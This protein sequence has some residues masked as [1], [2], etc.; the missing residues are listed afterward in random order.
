ML[1]RFSR[2]WLFVTP[3]TVVCQAPL[4]TGFSRQGY[5]SGL[6]CPPPGDLPDPGVKPESLLSPAL[7]GRFFTT[8]ATWEV[9][10][11]AYIKIYDYTDFFQVY[12]G[13]SK[14]VYL[15]EWKRKKI[16]NVRRENNGKWRH[17]VGEC[18]RQPGP[19]RCPCPKSWD[20]LPCSAGTLKILLRVTEL[21][22]GR[23]S[24]TVWVGPI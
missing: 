5:W 19:Q 4:S 24:W 8:S 23:L 1:S 18:D 6:P 22:I 20:M 12:I 15:I 13:H 11:E 3:W 9:H 17:S 14:S 10:E 2:V 16:I 21:E 7:A